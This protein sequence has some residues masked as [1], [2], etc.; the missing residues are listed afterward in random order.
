MLISQQ[1]R[2]QGKN[3]ATFIYSL[4]GA[5]LLL[6]VATLMEQLQGDAKR[7]SG[8][9]AHYAQEEQAKGKGASGAAGPAGQGGS[10]AA[11]AAA[12]GEEGAALRKTV[13]KLIKE[14]QALQEEAERCAAATKT[15]NAKADALLAQ[16]KGFDK[17]YDRLLDENKLL[18][19]RQAVGGG[20]G[21]THEAAPRRKDD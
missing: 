3:Q 1:L 7:V 5:L 10:A 11:A 9:Q 18:K 21:G 14:K 17:E 20:A 2:L 12:A 8:L 15:A 19:H 13:D 6:A 4:G 16:I